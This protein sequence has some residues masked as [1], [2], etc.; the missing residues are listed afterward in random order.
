MFHNLDPKDCKIKSS[1]SSSSIKGKGK[2]GYA[3]PLCVCACTA[4]W[5]IHRLPGD[6]GDTQSVGPNMT[7]SRRIAHTLL[8]RSNIVY[9]KE[10]MNHCDE[11]AK[12]EL[13]LIGII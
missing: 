13:G 4:L 6:R 12:A 8:W 2:G 3:R 11:V 10:C 7:I 1:S 9:A 5:G